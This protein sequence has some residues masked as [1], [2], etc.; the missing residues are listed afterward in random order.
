MGWTDQMCDYEA[1]AGGVVSPVLVLSI[2]NV[3]LSID[4]AG[5]RLIT[6]GCRLKKAAPNWKRPFSYSAISFSTA[7]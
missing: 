6:W 1:V 2:E 7:V 3:G 4:N 5:C